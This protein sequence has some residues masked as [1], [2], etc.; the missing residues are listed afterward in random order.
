MGIRRDETERRAEFTRD[1]IRGSGAPVLLLCHFPK[2]MKEP[3]WSDA[4]M[5]LQTVIRLLR[6]EG[7]DSCPQESLA[8]YGRT[9]KAELRLCN[10]TLLF[11][12]LSIGWRDDA[13]DVNNFERDRVPME[14]V[15]VRVFG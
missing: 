6:G 7:L 13:A 9:I 10:E 11:C 8:L 4:G 1:N 15:D 3:Q 12:G 2:L 5:W 14:Q